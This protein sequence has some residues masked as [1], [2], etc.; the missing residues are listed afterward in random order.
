MVMVVNKM[1]TLWDA[2]KKVEHCVMLMIVMMV[3]MPLLL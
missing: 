1:G 3:L 2:D